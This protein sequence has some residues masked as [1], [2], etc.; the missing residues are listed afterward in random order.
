[1]TKNL[2]F[3]TFW[4]LILNSVHITIGFN[5]TEFPTL[6]ITQNL[7]PTARP[8]L[9]VSTQ[10][11]LLKG[12]TLP[13]A[14]KKNNSTVS[15]FLGIP[16]AKP[17]VGDL[18][19]RPPEDPEDWSGIKLAFEQPPS[20]MQRPDVFFADFEGS[21]EGQPSMPPSEDCLYLNVFVP[22][23]LVKVFRGQGDEGQ[24]KDNLIRNGL[25]VLIWFHG[26][27]F[28]TG[29]SLANGPTKE[30]WFPDPRELAS[31]GEIIVVTVQYR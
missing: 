14:S 12:L 13:T 27:G 26:G 22:D 3:G 6:E 4:C 21:K 5:V 9:I 20:C 23:L 2:C 11:G 7:Q 8:P 30:E 28:S 16:Y 19:F 25:P 24:D 18:R 29:S 15:A 1:M 31:S 17:P 10:N